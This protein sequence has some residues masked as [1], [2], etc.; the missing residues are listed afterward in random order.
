MLVHGIEME[1]AG[2]RVCANWIK[3]GTF[4]PESLAI[5]LQAVRDGGLAIDV[6][7]YTGLYA[8]T[9]AAAGAP[10]IAY[11]PNPPVFAQLIRNVQRNRVTVDCRNTAVSDKIETRDFYTANRMTSAGRFKP[12]EGDSKQTVHCVTLGGYSHR[13]AAIKIDVEGAELA[14]LRGAEAILKRDRPVVIAEA[15]TDAAQ[16]S[17]VMH[18]TGRGY[19]WSIADR[20]NMVFRP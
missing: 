17:L 1:Q 11:E 7:A 19:K 14:V 13:V 9:A 4:E 10:A 20:R 6:G 12:R 3:D 15:L 8:I 18:M 2:C 5:W 16:R